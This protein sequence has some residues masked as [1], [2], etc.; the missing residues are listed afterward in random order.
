LSE[1]LPFFG[2]TERKDPRLL[3]SLCPV[4]D[5]KATRRL[6]SRAPFID[7]LT[8]DERAAGTPSLRLLSRS[9]VSRIALSTPSSA[10]ALLTFL[11]N[12]LFANQSRTDRFQQPDLT[13]G[14]Q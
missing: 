8:V 7:S 11:R 9:R 4:H 10:S 12:S 3:F 5:L 14:W 6:K 1:V 13:L 2:Q